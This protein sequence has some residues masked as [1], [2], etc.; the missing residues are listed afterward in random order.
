MSA[1]RTPRK[2]RFELKPPNS[3]V[4]EFDSET[5]EEVCVWWNSLSSN[6]RSE[7]VML[8]EEQM[9]MESFSLELVDEFEQLGLDEEV[10]DFYEYLVGHGHQ[11]PTGPY[12]GDRSIPLNAIAL[13]SP[14]WPPYPAAARYACWKPTQ[15]LYSQLQREYHRKE[16]GFFHYS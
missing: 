14:Y 2:R 1:E 12:H 6:E 10:N 7:L 11:S 15:A 13:L 8:C 3:L 4:E 5:Y 16:L 9:P